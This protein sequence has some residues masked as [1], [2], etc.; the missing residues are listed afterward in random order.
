MLVRLGDRVDAGQPLLRS[1]AK[2]DVAERVRPMLLAAVQ[3]SDEQPA[4]GPLILDRI[5]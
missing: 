4:V 3:L 5:A 1:F 2:R